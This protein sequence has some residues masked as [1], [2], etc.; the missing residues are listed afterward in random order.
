MAADK[1]T[2]GYHYSNKMNSFMQRRTAVLLSPVLL[3]PYL[4]LFFLISS[5]RKLNVLLHSAKNL[6]RLCNKKNNNNNL[7][8][9]FP[10]RVY[11]GLQG[12]HCSAKHTPGPNA[13]YSCPSW[14]SLSGMSLLSCTHI[15]K[16]AHHHNISCN[17]FQRLLECAPRGSGLEGGGCLPSPGGTTRLPNIVPH[18]FI[19]KNKHLLLGER[20]RRGLRK[21][22]TAERRLM[23]TSSS[24][25]PPPTN[26]T[27]TTA[28]GW[29]NKM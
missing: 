6:L 16:P 12:R 5:I 29:I 9:F 23:I 14:T 26:P 2:T 11:A 24:P 3:L 4:P 27:T 8:Q 10:G 1:T 7:K 20:R 22:G 13:N 28:W 18:I 21:G 15:P 19:R 25:A 17:W